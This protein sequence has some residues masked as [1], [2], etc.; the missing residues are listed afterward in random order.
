M[1]KKIKL[2]L[3][4]DIP[5]KHKIWYY[6]FIDDKKYSVLDCGALM[7]TSPFPSH[8]FQG[9]EA[10]E[11]IKDKLDVDNAIRADSYEEILEKI[12]NR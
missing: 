7:A 4:K 2:E 10:M 3:R 9:W 5:Y 1:K 12:L 11:I 8:V 6:L